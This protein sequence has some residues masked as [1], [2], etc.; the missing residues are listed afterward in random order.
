MTS[1]LTDH[2]PLILSLPG[3]AVA[4][5]VWRDQVNKI[6]SGNA[7]AYVLLF[8]RCFKATSLPVSLP[9]EFNKEVSVR[10][11]RSDLDIQ[12]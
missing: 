1:L 10:G 4:G 8:V 9:F 3:I 11:I 6:G 5:A 7:C 12:R 2:A